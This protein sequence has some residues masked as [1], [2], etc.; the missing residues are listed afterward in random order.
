MNIVTL[1]RRVIINDKDWTVDEIIMKFGRVWVY[2]LTHEDTDGIRDLVVGTNTSIGAMNHNSVWYYNNS[3]ADLSPDFD[4]QQNDFLQDEMIETGS[5]AL[6]VLFDHNGDGLKDLIVSQH[7]RYNDVTGL[8]ECR[9]F[10]FENT[11]TAALPEFTFVSEDYQ[12]FSLLGVGSGL[13]YYPAFGD[14][15]NDGDEDMIVGD[16][17]GYCYYFENTGGAGS[18]ALFTT[19]DTLRNSAG[20]P[21]FNSTYAYPAIVDLDRDGDNDVVIGRRTGLLQYYENTGSASAMQ[22]EFQTGNLGGV[23][24][25]EYWS[26]EGQAVPVFLDIEGEYHLVLGSKSGALHYYDDIDANLAGDF[27][28]VD[29]TLDNLWIGTW[30]APAIYDLNGDDKFDM[31]LGNQRG[32]VSLFSSGSISQIGIPEESMEITLYPNPASNEIVINTN[33]AEALNVRFFALEGK[34]VNSVN[35]YSSGAPIDISQLS[36]GVY[37]IMISSG[38]GVVSEKLTIVR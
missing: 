34:E 19:F 1:I 25:S 27:N 23:D 7:Q 29:S 31:I 6:P 28:L 11:G 17:H 3:G 37:T 9:M 2:G 32:G 16:Y 8:Y 21:I 4:Y 13:S 22:L 24:V 26:I 10:Y 35:G 20:E 36:D 18:P 14:L 15:D 5:G 12:N 33:T 38:S 30:S